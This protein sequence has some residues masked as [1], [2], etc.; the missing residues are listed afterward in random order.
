MTPEE[1]RELFIRLEEYLHGTPIMW[2]P[3]ENP[4]A[5]WQP[6]AP[7]RHPLDIWKMASNQGEF[8]ILW[9]SHN[10]LIPGETYDLF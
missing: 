4:E 1:T 2:R 3:L 9:G 8:Q 5:A 6:V 10:P 7:Y